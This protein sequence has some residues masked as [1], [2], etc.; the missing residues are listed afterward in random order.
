MDTGIIGGTFNPIHNGH[1]KIAGEL[2]EQCQLD[3]VIFIPAAEPPHKADDDIAPFTQRLAMTELAMTAYPKF[4]VSNIEAQRHGKSYSVDT[5]RQLHQH[6]PDDQ[7][8]FLIGMDSFTAISTWHNYQQLFKLCNLIV[9]RRPGTTPQDNPLKLPVAIRQQFCYDAEL[10]IYR[11]R[12]GQRLIFLKKTFLDISST[13]IRTKIAAHQPIDL[14]VP[15]S[16]AEY[17]HTHNLYTA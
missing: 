7:F 2:L 16:V 12:C 4:T 10:D 14:L 17:I 9:A 1:L 6:Y 5:L 3:R 8:F 11:H 13:A 15:A